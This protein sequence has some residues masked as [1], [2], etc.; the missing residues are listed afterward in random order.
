MYHNVAKKPQQINNPTYSSHGRQKNHNYKKKKKKKKKK[1]KNQK[2]KKKKKKKNRERE[3][4]IDREMPLIITHACVTTHYLKVI[5][6][7]RVINLITNFRFE[8]R[9]N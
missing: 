4:E 2:K 1:N 8:P 9:I 3:R 5:D 6:S 7:S